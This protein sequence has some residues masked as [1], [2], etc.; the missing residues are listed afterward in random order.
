M[1]DPIYNTTASNSGAITSEHHEIGSL[2]GLPNN[3]AAEPPITYTEI[4]A[5]GK[6][7]YVKEFPSQ[8][9]GLASGGDHDTV[10]PMDTD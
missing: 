6:T 10:N 7:I 2:N 9:A 8:S 4:P 1:P 5:V 3:E